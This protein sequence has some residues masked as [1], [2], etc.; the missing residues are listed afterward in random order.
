MD[1]RLNMDQVLRQ[2]RFRL[3]YNPR[4]SSQ[5]AELFF[6]RRAWTSKKYA[7]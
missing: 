6:W 2:Q 3:E 1:I 5:F 4:M 7:F